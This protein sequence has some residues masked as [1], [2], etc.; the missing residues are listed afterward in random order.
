MNYLAGKYDQGPFFSRKIPGKIYAGMKEYKQLIIQIN[1][2]K[3]ILIIINNQ[4]FALTLNN[5]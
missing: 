2:V 3:K 1:P 5:I 4:Y